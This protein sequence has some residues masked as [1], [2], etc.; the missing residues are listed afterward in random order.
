[1]PKDTPISNTKRNL[2]FQHPVMIKPYITGAVN[3]SNEALD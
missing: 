3:W 1:M 2:M